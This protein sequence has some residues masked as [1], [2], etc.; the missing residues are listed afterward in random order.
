MNHKSEIFSAVDIGT[1]TI[2]VLIG[3]FLD[4]EE[5]NILSYG[6]AQSKRML[7]GEPVQV[8][9]VSECLAKAV[10]NALE[11][12]GEKHLPGLVCMGLGGGYIHPID[13][14]I[15]FDMGGD[16]QITRD[17]MESV[18]A[19]ACD[20]IA[21]PPDEELLPNFLCR[22]FVLDDGKLLSDPIGQFAKSLLIK[23]ICQ[24][25]IPGRLSTMT[26]MVSDFCPKERVDYHAYNPVAVGAALFSEA[27]NKGS[28]SLIIDIG[29]GVT[30]VVLHN[31]LSHVF[32]DQV[33]V[34]CDNIANDLGV[35]LNMHI[36]TCRQIVREMANI[37]CSTVA[38]KD[39]TARYI[40]I[41]ESK[42]T[43][44]AYAS[45][46]E[47][48]VEARLRELFEI[49]REKMERSHAYE[50]VGRD[51]ILS[52]G[53]AYLPKI[54]EL[55]ASV[56]GRPAR[57][58]VA[59]NVHFPADFPMERR[60]FYNTAVGLLRYA[61]KELEIG[62]SRQMSK[63]NRFLRAVDWLRNIFVSMGE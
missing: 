42:N 44:T 10:S 52:G 24:S 36:E 18:L 37:R 23:G 14:D 25:Y 30:S 62:R 48:I 46:V 56:F 54:T 51:V 6:E 11:R 59:Q 53:G 34:G 61:H 63:R 41:Q 31:Q 4:G 38:T 13:S 47:T 26:N 16:S 2:K 40:S 28:Y 50:W 9:V 1:A 57:I 45:A 22:G 20:A 19:Q 8:N 32:C 29:A 17:F 27:E 58:G 43:H 12:L 35:G 3:E 49:I 15:S 39:G 33:L 7:K 55:A 60:G 5:L 21:P